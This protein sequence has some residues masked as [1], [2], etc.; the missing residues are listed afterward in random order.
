VYA[1]GTF[2][3]TAR[4]SVD[5]QNQIGVTHMTL[6]TNKF[7][8]S[9]L[10]QVANGYLVAKTRKEALAYLSAKAE[11]TKRKRWINAAKAAAAGDDLRMAAYAAEGR[12]ATNAAWAAV[13]REP[14]ADVTPIKPK[15][16]AKAKAVAKP[17]ANPSAMDALTEQVLALDEAA[18]TSFTAALIAAKRK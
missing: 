14:K 12:E 16:K 1:E 9:T 5:L 7:A 2:R 13:P 8:G 18:F 3:G 15:A 4:L 17:K 10:T 11:V 6:A